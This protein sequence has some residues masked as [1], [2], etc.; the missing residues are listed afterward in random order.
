MPENEA[1]APQHDRHLVV[2]LVRHAAGEP[3]HGFEPMRLHQLLLQPA[4][5]GHLL[6]RDVDADGPAVGAV[7]REPGCHPDAARHRAAPRVSPRIS[8]SRP[9][10]P[11]AEHLAQPGLQEV[12]E[13]GERLAHGSPQ[14]RRRPEARSSPPALVDAEV[15]KVCV[16]DAEARPA[17]SGIR[18]RSPRAGPGA[19]SSLRRS[20]SCCRYRS[21]TSPK[22]QARVRRRLARWPRG[23]SAHAEVPVADPDLGRAAVPGPPASPS[24]GTSS[25]SRCPISSA[26]GRASEPGKG[27]V[28]ANDPVRPPPSGRPDR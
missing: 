19:S 17:P 5:L 12:G 7:Q 10:A 8:K 4:P 26:K 22:T 9:A 3:A 11:V 13:L 1:G 6:G 24:C 2:G 20:A 21:V 23:R 18:P 16:Q 27:G 25:S 14:V 15:P 28:A